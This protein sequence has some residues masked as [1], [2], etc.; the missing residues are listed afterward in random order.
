M[1]T[2]KKLPVAGAVWALDDWRTL[3]PLTAPYRP[4][5]RWL[6]GGCS[7][8]GPFPG[9]TCELAA[10]SFEE[11]NPLLDC[12]TYR[13][14]AEAVAPWVRQWNAT[15]PATGEALPPPIEA[16]SD[17]FDKLD[18]GLL[19][20]LRDMLIQAPLLQSMIADELPPIGQAG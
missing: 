20:W 10:L 18:K 6:V 17:V 9:L 15:D 2:P 1:N 13:H 14:L 19:L 12:L 5:R 3:Q 11:S 16:G 8:V 7:A 4:E